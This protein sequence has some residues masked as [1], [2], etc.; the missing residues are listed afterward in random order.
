MATID[1]RIAKLEATLKE[2]KAKKQ[3]IEARKRAVESKQKRAT[4]T[5]KKILIGAAI[6]SMIERG[7]WSA[8]NLQQIMDQTLIRDDDRALFNL[9][10]K[11][12]T[13]G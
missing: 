7:Q 6:Q 11:V 4:E 13:S 8:E 5:R 2:A 10:P 1:E 3:Q 12:T 9:P